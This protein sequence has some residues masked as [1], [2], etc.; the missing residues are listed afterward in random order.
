MKTLELILHS[1]SG[2][3]KKSNIN[4]TPF[5]SVIYNL[6]GVYFNHVTRLKRQAT[7]TH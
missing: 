2:E 7:K 6:M 3:E 5:F 1:I 4:G